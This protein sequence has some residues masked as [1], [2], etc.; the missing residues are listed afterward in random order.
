MSICKFQNLY[1]FQNNIKAIKVFLLNDFYISFE[2]FLIYFNIILNFKQEMVLILQ[3]NYRNKLK[4]RKVLRIKDN[5]IRSFRCVVVCQ[6][7]KTHQMNVRTPGSGQ[8]ELCQQLQKNTNSPSFEAVPEMDL[9]REIEIREQSIEDFQKTYNEKHKRNNQIISLIV[10]VKFERTD[11]MKRNL[12]SVI[13]YFRRFIDLI[14]I[15]VT[16]FDQSENLDEDKENL[17]KSLKF[18]VK[19]DE[20]RIFFSQNQNQIDEIRKL[21]SVIEKIDQNKQQPFS[22]KDT[23]FEEIDDSQNQNILQLENDVKVQKF[24]FFYLQYTYS[25]LLF[26]ILH[27]LYEFQQTLIISK[28]QVDNPKY[29]KPPSN[30]YPP[31]FNTLSKFHEH[32]YSPGKRN[33]QCK[34][35][36]FL[37]N[38]RVQDMKFLIRNQQSHLI[39]GKSKNFDRIYYMYMQNKKK[40]N[41]IIPHNF[42]FIGNYRLQKFLIKFKSKYGQQ[43]TYQSGNLKISDNPYTPKQQMLGS[44]N[45]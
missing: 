13:K 14:I 17:K 18:L 4:K 38:A 10:S 21:L 8:S 6:A 16:Y 28:K 44:C 43:D 7:V 35:L 22:L 34:C 23:I 30:K 31:N 39:L 27:Q 24:P 26:I 40:F 25:N 1:Q 36:S 37:L 9:D 11:I 2:I 20:E 19:N 42:C 32:R 5:N 41:R 15:V 29:L 3:Q 33:F 45:R 12:L